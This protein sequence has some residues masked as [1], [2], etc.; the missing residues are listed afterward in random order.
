[1][2]DRC[3][4]CSVERRYLEYQE[5]GVNSVYT[6]K[7]V[8]PEC[9]C[10]EDPRKNYWRQSLANWKSMSSSWNLSQA[11]YIIVMQLQL[12]KLQRIVCVWTLNVW[13]CW[14][15]AVLMRY[16]R[17]QLKL[18]RKLKILTAICRASLTPAITISY[19]RHCIP[20]CKCQTVSP[21]ST[22]SMLKRDSNSDWRYGH[23][24][25]MTRKCSSSPTLSHSV[26]CFCGYIGWLMQMFNAQVLD[27]NPWMHRVCRW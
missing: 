1:M 7:E 27:A 14:R 23:L 19:G 3:V 20:A 4:Q 15:C 21:I 17:L 13:W 25:T 22:L 2:S 12:I 26:I 5:I 16:N 24:F 18:K 9:G 6:G 11:I 10:D 8:A